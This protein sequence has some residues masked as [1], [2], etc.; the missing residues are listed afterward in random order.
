V[1]SLYIDLIAVA[2]IIAN[3]LLGWRF[4][5]IGRALALG[6]LYGGV[7]AATAMGNRLLRLFGGGGAANDLYSSAWM[8][9]GIVFAVIAMVEILAALY[10]ERVEKVI[11]LMFD[12]SSGVVAGLVVGVLQAAVVMM[13]A[14]AVGDASA[15]V[16]GQKLPNERGNTANAVRNSVI[17]SHIAGLDPAVKTFFGPALP[18][19][20]AGYLADTTTA[21]TATTTT[22]K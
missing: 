6:G 3:L 17:G 11:S 16:P 1:T 12:R 5:I 8:F 7:A 19:S 14:L 10:R 21:A 9:I 2:L 20:L 22:S 15:G 13:V 4:G 18:S